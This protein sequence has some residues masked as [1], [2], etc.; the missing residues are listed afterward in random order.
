MIEVN[1]DTSDVVDNVSV[2]ITTNNGSTVNTSESTAVEVIPDNFV[3]SSTGIFTGN[4]DGSVPIWLTDAI[5]TQRT[6][7]DGNLSTVVADLA[8]LVGT[9]QTGVNQNIT[10]IQT[11]T[12]SVS[13][14]ET[15]VV[16][17]LD[18]NEAGILNLD[19]TKVTETEA[20]AISANVVSSTFGGDAD[21]YIGNISS[22]YVD[23]NSA[24][25]ADIEALTVSFNGTNV[26][27]SETNQVVAGYYSEWDG[28]ATPLLGQFKFIG[29]TQYQF[30]GGT[31]GEASDG[32][33][34]TDYSSAVAIA[35]L[36]ETTGITLSELQAQIDGEIT[37][38]F[39]NYVPTSLNEP[40]ATW[41]ATD[42]T[43]GDT[44]EQTRH[45]GDLFYD[46]DTGGAYRFIDTAGVFSWSL[47]TD[48]AV[49][50]ALAAAASAQG[51]ADKKRVIYY[52]DT[53]PTG[54]VEAPL[55]T[56]DM[57][58]P[59]VDVSTYTAGVIYI[60]NAI[61]LTWNDATRYTDN[62]Y[63]E[64]IV[65]GTNQVDLADHTDSLGWNNSITTLGTDVTNIIDGTTAIVLD[66]A[67]VSGTVLGT[68]VADEIDKEV[69]V[70]SGTDHTVQTGMKLND[71]FIESAVD[72]SGAL[73]VDVTNTYKYSGTAW[74][75]INTNDNLTALA[76]VTD[77]KRTIYRGT[78]APT[79]MQVNDI[80][81]P[82]TGVVGYDA[83]ELY[84]YSGIAWVKTTKY[85]DD[86]TIDSFLTVTYAQDMLDIGTQSDGVATSYFQ[87]TE[88]YLA[89]AGT[90]ENTGDTWFNTST[91]AL[92]RFK[93]EY[94][95]NSIFYPSAWSTITNQT[96]IDAYIAAASTKAAADRSIQNFTSEPTHPYFIGDTWM[97]GAT[98]DIYVCNTDSTTVFDQAHWTAASKYTDNTVADEAHTWAANASKL[99]T[100]PNG[101]ITGWQ[102]ADGSGVPSQFRINADTFEVASG[103]TN[104]TP[105]T[106]NTIDGRV[107][108]N[109][110]VT[111]TSQQVADTGLS[112]L[113]MDYTGALNAEL[114]KPT[115]G[116]KINYSDLTT[117]DSGECY[118][119]G[120]NAA[121]VESTD[122]W[123]V[124]LPSGETY[125]HA[126]RLLA[127][128]LASR[129]GY[130][131]LDTQANGFTVLFQA[132]AF[133]FAFFTNVGGTTRWFYDN[134]LGTFEFSPVNG[135]HVI[136]GEIVTD[137]VDS[138]SEGTVYQS[139]ITF[140][141]AI[142]RSNNT[143][144]DNIYTAG[145]T[146]I[147]GGIITTNTV[148]AD[149]ILAGSIW[150]DG[151]IQSTDFVP[152]SA[153]FRLKA[154]A[155]GTFADPTIYGAYIRGGV[156]DGTTVSARDLVIVTDTGLSTA[157][158]VSST[159]T[160]ATVS[161]YVDG[162]LGTTPN[163]VSLTYSVYPHNSSTGSTTNR[164]ASD[165][166]TG[167][168]LSGRQFSYNWTVNSFD[169]FEYNGYVYVGLVRS[170]T[171]QLRVRFGN[172]DSGYTSITDDTSSTINGL[173]FHVV[174]GTLPIS[175][176][177]SF[178]FIRP[179][180]NLTSS[181]GDGQLIINLKSSTGELTAGVSN[182]LVAYNI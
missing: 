38:W 146:T 106:V 174:S 12:Q 179:S 88:P 84:Q 91:E 117:P 41:L 158:V 56:N 119:H 175:T 152:F 25:A 53:V 114:N 155:A 136:M 51:T 85:T 57:W 104:Y 133:A 110:Y 168:Q 4:L 112:V 27:L 21:A 132:V 11:T 109:G 156:L 60:Y 160:L 120:F 154:N 63:A 100:D 145:T 71:I 103:T 113:D 140:Q 17:R 29:D 3:L 14:L 77:G 126:S 177:Y 76:D 138:V 94:T 149:K 131:M 20:T 80:W 26:T 166:S 123:S 65:N 97:Q 46:T 148:N 10:D 107:E 48:T 55:D 142:R 35:S 69:V 172:Y 7:G 108:F 93:Y 102:F 59:S 9:L 125:S 8:A 83:E 82:E 16:S 90:S 50:A 165:S 42:T 159:S 92:K 87:A 141:E 96:I 18:S 37:S 15:S 180:N 78:T 115:V 143:V 68:Y 64:D 167:I 130:I 162:V 49:T 99:I 128:Q 19:V 151:S 169:L 176:S 178:V 79:G 89:S 70:F 144:T 86:S 111:F 74:V 33:V 54:S 182:N 101:N 36:E 23:A 13:A 47:V 157:S 153:G 31:L 22:T 129:S 2:E 30:L 43:N 181:L 52:Q 28:I 1:S 34:Q 127:T 75:Q 170:A 45:T 6:S 39:D 173:E 73:P 137:G 62:Q 124:L 32:W 61:A 58:I 122:N 134:G 67:T 72:S 147:N 163:E 105:L 5:Q 121:G 135:R 81:I 161:T 171:A 44:V 98:G 116:F 40:W 24:I 95:L 164:V 150:T 66:N 139:A 118:L